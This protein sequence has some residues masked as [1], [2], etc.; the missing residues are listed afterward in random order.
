MAPTV[1]AMFEAALKLS[2]TERVEL[3]DR[4]L[5]SISPQRQS[6]V[7]EAWAAEAERRYS[8]FKEGKLASIDYHDAMRSIRERLK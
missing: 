4:L 5:C 2:E 1:D 3:A 7:D 6:E 8:A